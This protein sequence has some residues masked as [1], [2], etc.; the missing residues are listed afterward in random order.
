VDVILGVIG[1]IIVYNQL[2]PFDIDTTRGDVGG[3][4][5]AVFPLFEAFQ[6]LSPLGKGTVGV[7]F[8]GTVIHSAYSAGNSLGAEFRPAKDKDRSA[9]LLECFLELDMLFILAEHENLLF[10]IF[11]GGSCAGN[12]DADWQFHMG[13]GDFDNLI[14]HGCREQHRLSVA[15]NSHKN[16]LNLRSK[17]HIEHTV[18]FVQNQHI[19]IIQVKAFLGEVVDYS[20]G[21]ANDDMGVFAES[22][23]LGLPRR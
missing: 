5:D 20:S 17:T 7:D 18:G 23:Q 6:G 4:Q 8:G 10:H 15:W 12:F 14:G 3:N 11:S 1:D 21:C 2:N 13:C 9:V 19:D 22:H 16:P